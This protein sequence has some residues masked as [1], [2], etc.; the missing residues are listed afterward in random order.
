MSTSSAYRKSPP[1]EGVSYRRWFWAFAFLN[2]AAAIWVVWDETDTRR[3]WKDYQEEFNDVLRARS[4]PTLPIEIRQRSNP[5]LGIVD[6]CESCHLGIDDA[7]LEGAALPRVFQVHPRRQELL[8]ANHRTAHM[9]CTSCHR[10]QGE[11][12]KG[13]NRGA[14][15]HGR[16]DPYWDKP[17]LTGSFV[18]ST[19]VGCHREQEPIPGAEVFNHGR[20]LFAEKRCFGCHATPLMNL[21]FAA[22]PSLASL[23]AKTSRQFVERW[24]EDPRAFR[25]STA[26]PN[27]WPVPLDR[28]G[29]PYPPGS[30]TY[31]LWQQRRSQEV[32]AIA[33]FL[34]SVATSKLPPVEIPA[35]EQLQAAEQIQLGAR[36]FDEVGCRGC[37]GFDAVDKAPASEEDAEDS[38]ESD[39]DSAETDDS[40]DD[41]TDESG[42]GAETDDSAGTD[43]GGDVAG[44]NDGV[45]VDAAA[46]GAVAAANPNL[47]HAVSLSSFAPALD[48][49]GEKATAAWLAA[50]LADPHSVSAKT[51]MPMMR[52]SREERDALVA[53]LVS[54]RQE[55]AAAVASSWPAT[56][57]TEVALGEA[58][59]QKYGCYGCHEIP[60]FEDA[61][62][63]G[64]DLDD[65]GDKTTDRLTWG[66]ALNKCDQPELEC[67]TVNKF[68]KPRWFAAENL[69]LYM[70]DMALT[71]Q[72]ATALAV[73]V[74]ANRVYQIP[75]Q[76]QRILTA[77]ERVLRDGERLLTANNCRG[78]HEIGRSEKKIYDEDGE[79][80]RYEYEP[81]GGAIRQFY[82]V[83]SSAP[84][85]LT[86]AGK[87]F[88]YEWIY[89]FLTLPSRVRPWLQVRMPSFELSDANKT[90][91]V[92][93]F[94]AAN[95]MPY[96]L[97]QRNQPS[98]LDP[99]EQKEAV[100]LFKQFQC[101]RC[102]VISGADTLSEGELA[103]DLAQ[104]NTR[105]RADWI[106]EWLVEPQR[107]QP[108]TKM[109]TFY[110][111][112]DPEDPSTRISPC[113]TCMD[114]D[115]ERQ[116]DALVDVCLR[117]ADGTILD[118]P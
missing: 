96:P 2:F 1:T 117:L 95:E 12:T 98:H 46:K 35:A 43:D 107:L 90:T 102:H 4:L 64:A 56:T 23:A 110:P 29:T 5:A 68:L 3:P 52:L 59:I 71:A 51:R 87:K 66:D 7:R 91:L 62:R 10:G 14:F 85:P 86:F 33:A 70:P 50:W 11:Q 30:A 53:Y 34:G 41:G 74:M 27:F 25:P 89:E 92:E 26:M 73:F 32:A 47:R 109:P 55:P 115:I 48:R 93:Y 61:G 20:T 63:P 106:R 42:E 75:S 60:G 104:A 111:A 38:A 79:F 103:P 58:L 80:D 65:F 17:M 15:D 78:C 108:G 31:Q 40:S 118:A 82:P 8:G 114:G 81:I 100:A 72:E 37:H 113:D 24:L 44:T 18:E 69:E 105:L 112:E 101:Y 97:G 88:Q 19:C 84:P 94:A 49:I 45:P 21:E 83:T 13:I 67:W 76:Y 28:K 54:L 36:L 77:S 22:A 6:R 116:V 16:G 39:G 9:G 57:A 99:V